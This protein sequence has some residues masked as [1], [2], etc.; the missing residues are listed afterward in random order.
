M[1]FWVNPDDQWK[2][3]KEVFSSITT[4][5]QR[6]TLFFGIACTNES[7]NKECV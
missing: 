4:R 5:L 7:L 3:K 6:L 1:Y 2:K